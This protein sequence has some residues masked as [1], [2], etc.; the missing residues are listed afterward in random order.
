M[1]TIKT[2]GTLANG[3]RVNTNMDIYHADRVEELVDEVNGQK[4]VRLTIY[5]NGNSHGATE[6]HIPMDSD[7][8]RGPTS[9]FV[10]N[11]N[12]RTVQR[13]TTD[14]PWRDIPAN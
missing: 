14:I 12:G 2:T 5:A 13:I 6:I 3:E 7:R 10:E 4:S 9:V 11:A 1:F 8:K